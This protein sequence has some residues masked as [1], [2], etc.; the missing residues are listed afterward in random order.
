M[1]IILSL[2]ILFG[3]IVSLNCN[4]SGNNSTSQSD[5]IVKIKIINRTSNN[6]VKSDTVL[7]NQGDLAE[8][9]GQFKLMKEVFNTNT[10]YHF[11]FYEVKVFHKNGNV[12]NIDII[13]TV[14]DG[15]VI[16]NEN[17]GKYYKNNQ[18]DSTMLYYLR[19]K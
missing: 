3:G 12:D 10:K 2:I 5:T 14:F 9:T 16:A 8:I 6:Y 13:Y 4:L 17:T 19:E 7:T 15:V 11:G 1:K 18:L